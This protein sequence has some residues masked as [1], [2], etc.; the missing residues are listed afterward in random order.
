VRWHLQGRLSR[1]Q[2][3]LESNPSSRYR[4]GKEDMKRRKTWTVNFSPL[5]L[6]ADE[7]LRLR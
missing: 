4:E 2:I 1:P 3:E 7:Q 6:V 5:F